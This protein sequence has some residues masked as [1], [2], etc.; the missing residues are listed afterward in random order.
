MLSLFIVLQQLLLQPVYRIIFL[1]IPIHFLLLLLLLLV[2][3][4][5][6]ALVPLS[7]N[8]IMIVVVIVVRIEII[9]RELSA[10][11]LFL[12]HLEHLVVLVFLVL[13]IMIKALAVLFFHSIRVMR[14]RVVEAIILLLGLH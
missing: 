5:E 6:V 12:V 14:E 1:V 9:N 2:I 11:G 13:T 8:A 4:N 3:E 10:H 7:I